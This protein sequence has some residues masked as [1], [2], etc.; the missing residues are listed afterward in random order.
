M[1][2]YHFISEQ[3]GLED[4]KFRRLKIALLDELNDPFELM[5]TDLSDDQFHQGMKDMKNHLSKQRGILCF[6]EIWDNPVLW[7]HYANGHKGLCLGVDVPNEL[8][9]KINYR[10]ERLSPDEFIAY[11][12][13]VGSDLENEMDDYIGYPINWENPETKERDFVTIVRQRLG[14]VIE[15]DETG[16]T[17][18]KKILSTKFSHWSYERE[19]RVF[20]PLSKE[21]N[22]RYYYY[23]SDDL[24]L[25]EVIVGIRSYVTRKKVEEML[26]E[27]ANIVSIF[28]VREDLRR[29]AVVR[30][31]NLF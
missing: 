29:F 19:Y 30:D 13:A 3:Y 12:N 24:K 1:R 4:I 28:K 16:Q 27:I 17:F 25:K 10:D 26:G 9:M 23:F 31:E 21:I 5:G 11:Q 18:I 15:E 22:G 8:L 14:E 7:A 20:A 6:S 2:V